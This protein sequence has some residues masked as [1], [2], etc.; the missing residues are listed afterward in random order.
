MK[1]YKWP[2]GIYALR[3]IMGNEITEKQLIIQNIKL[4]R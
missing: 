1:K 4:F 3:A 2:A